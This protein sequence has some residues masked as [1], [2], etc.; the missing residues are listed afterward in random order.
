MIKFADRIIRKLKTY[1]I[2]LKY[3]HCN[4]AGEIVVLLRKLCLENGVIPELT[5]PYT[6]HQNGVME[7]QFTVVVN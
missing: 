5:K 6:P 2:P 3:L 7:R 1:E 4:N